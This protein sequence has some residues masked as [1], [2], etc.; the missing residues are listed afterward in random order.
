AF[1]CGLG[2]LLWYF[3]LVRLVSHHQAKFQEKTFKKLLI[4]LGSLLMA[5]AIFT[6]ISAFATIKLAGQVF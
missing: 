4:I 2:A 1:S 6:F 5:F 3:F